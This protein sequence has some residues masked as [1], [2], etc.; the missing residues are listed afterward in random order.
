MPDQTTTSEPIGGTSPLGGADTKVDAPIA[1]AHGAEPVSASDALYPGKQDTLGGDAPAPEGD[2]GSDTVEVK[3]DA[4]SA[5]SDALTPDSY[6]LTT[7]EGF[8][9]NE[10][11]LAAFKGQMATANVP[12]EAAQSLF[13]LYASQSAAAATAFETAQTAAWDSTITAW[14]AERLADPTIGGG[15]VAVVDAA[16]GR[17]LDEYGGATPAERQATRSAFDLTGAGHNPAVIRLIYSMASALSEGSPVSGARPVG[18]T[19]AT[20][21]ERLYGTPAN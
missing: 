4:A 15:N 3:S 10:E 13:D 14:K 6:T 7:P 18:K 2:G 5:S 16:I 1:P 12:P 21:A 19:N 8:V 11:A 20:P 17:A 9:V